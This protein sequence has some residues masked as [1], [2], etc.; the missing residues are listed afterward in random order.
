MAIWQRKRKITITVNNNKDE[1]NCIEWAKN[2]VDEFVVTYIFDKEA[3]SNTSA[4]KTEVENNIKLYTDEAEHKKQQ[5]TG[6]QMQKSYASRIR[7]TSSRKTKQK[8][9]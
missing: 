3:I 5:D 4:I 8:K 6:K 9:H 2:A 1:N 7:Y